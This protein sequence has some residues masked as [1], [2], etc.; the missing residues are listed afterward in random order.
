MTDRI[1]TD[2]DLEALL[3]AARDTRP[4]PSEALTRRV[5]ADAADVQAALTRPAAPVRPRTRAGLWRQ[6]AD[7]L[8]G[9]PGIGGLA[10]ACAAGVWL[11][12]APPAALP[13]PVSLVQDRVAAADL[14]LLGTQ[15]LA[16][17]LAQED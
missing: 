5:L 4:A 14:D 13:D 7:A 2:T 1:R 15:D 17:A 8:G 3:D 6:L 10:A 16:L 9:W 12:F 11:G